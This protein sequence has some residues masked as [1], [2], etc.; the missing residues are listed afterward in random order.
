MKKSVLITGAT[1]GIGKA[2]GDVFAAGGYN[3]VVTGRRS[4]RLNQLCAE[5]R[6]TYGTQV[7]PLCFDVRDRRSTFEVLTEWSRHATHLDVLVNN[8]G[9]ALGREHFD[10]ADMDEWDTMID[11][12]VKGLLYVTKALMPLLLKS[13]THILNIGSIAGKEVYEYGNVYCATKAAVDAISRSMRIDLLQYGN[14][15]TVIHP[16]A[17]ETEFSVVRYRGDQAKADA[18]YQGFT[19]LTGKDVAEVAFYCAQL[20]AHVCINE[21]EITPTRQAGA[22]YIRREPSG[23]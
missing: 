19:P 9:L 18:V 14:K 23:R 6:Q 2:C 10:K 13:Q 22:H 1:S 5:W 17:A 8:A 21:L 15:V 20:P 4:D 7:T 12:N 3:L 16:G 11:T